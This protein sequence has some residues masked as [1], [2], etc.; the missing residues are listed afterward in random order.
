MIIILKQIPV[1]ADVQRVLWLYQVQQMIVFW[2]PRSWR[3]VQ[4]GLR[5]RPSLQVCIGAGR[6]RSSASIMIVLAYDSLGWTWIQPGSNSTPAC[7]QCHECNWGSGTPDNPHPPMLL[8]AQSWSLLV[9]GSNDPSLI[10]HW[11]LISTVLYHH[12]G[13]LMQTHGVFSRTPARRV[14]LV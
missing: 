2:I 4:L 7:L 9:R 14:W 6:S 8:S 12:G 13:R 3:S 11:H 5:T 1:D 10:Q